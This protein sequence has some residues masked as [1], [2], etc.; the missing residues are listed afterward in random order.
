MQPPGPGLLASRCAQRFSSHFQ[1]SS[2]PHREVAPDLLVSNS[3]SEPGKT[4]FCCHAPGCYLFR[5]VNL[6]L[7]GSSET[8][9][10]DASSSMLMQVARRACWL[11]GDGHGSGESIQK[12]STSR[13]NH[14]FIISDFVLF[15]PFRYPPRLR[16]PL[17]LKS[18]L[19]DPRRSKDS[20]R[21]LLGPSSTSVS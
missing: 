19:L 7:W 13:L 4:S 18:S 11:H 1:T 2:D 15:S 17:K 14:D 6:L 3:P 20:E 5:S 8:F 21:V 12:H 10:L 16:K 9:S